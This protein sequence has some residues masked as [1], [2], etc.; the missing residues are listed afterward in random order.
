[1]DETNIFYEE[2][3]GGIKHGEPSGITPQSPYNWQQPAIF[4]LAF[5]C[6]VAG[7]VYFFSTPT[8]NISEPMILRVERGETISGLAADLKMRGL[9]RSAAVFQLAFISFYG[10]DALKAGDYYLEQTPDMWNLAHR[11][12]YG[13]YGRSEV[14]VTIPEG[15]TTRDIAW[16]FENLGAFRAEEFWSVVGRPAVDYRKMR[17]SAPNFDDVAEIV[18]AKPDYLGMEG[19]L[20]PDTYFFYVPLSPRAI[21][22]AMLKNMDQ[23]FSVELRAKATARKLS[24]H[25]VLTMASILEEEA[26]TPEDRRIISGILWKRI[27]IGMALQVDASLIYI[28]GK[29]GYKLT[30]NDLNMDSPY[31]TYKHAGLPPGPI[32]SPGLDAII[33]AIEPQ[34]SPYL[35]YL[36]DKSGVMHYAKTFEEHKA[37][38][39]KYLR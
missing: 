17:E 22:E 38:K 27:K 11:L 28:I 21:A 6:I 32:A 24:T 39:Q 35:Y 18:R 19:Y 34:A 12:A 14:R 29:P 3:V 20:F 7:L 33:S 25:D 16:H 36:S 2:K 37:N 23:K 13:V 5:F 30:E 8:K 31:N 26:A 4:I 1:M 10:G 15:W 9:V